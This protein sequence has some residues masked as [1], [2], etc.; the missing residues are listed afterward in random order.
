LL[1]CILFLLAP[2]DLAAV[3]STCRDL[4][5]IATGDL[6]WREI[7][8]ANVPG[9]KV[10]SPYP[11]PSFRHLYVAHELRWFLPKY[12]IWFCDS[13]LTGKLVVA[14]YDPRTGNIE[15]Y[16]LLGISTSST[17]YPWPLDDDVNVHQFEPT[18]KLHLDRPTV[19][20][21]ADGYGHGHEQQYTELPITRIP[22]RNGV[23]STS[24]L[25]IL[26]HVTVGT[27]LRAEIPM[28]GTG[29]GDY[30]RSSFMLAR[31]LQPE[32]TD[33]YRNA[34]G[35]VRLESVWP[36]PAIPAQIRIHNDPYMQIDRPECRA[37]VCEQAFWIRTRWGAAAD[38][39]GI[40]AVLGFHTNDDESIN[41]AYATLDPK[42]YTPTSR[43]PYRGI[44][45][46]DY[47][48]HGC[49][50]L[51]IHQPDDPD[52]DF[53]P[54]TI[55]RRHDETDGEFAQRRADETVFRGRLEAIKLT[56]DPNV[57]RGQCTFVAEDLGE[58]GLV[59]VVPGQE[60]PFGGARIV[61]SRGHVADDGFRNGGSNSPFCLCC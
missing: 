32:H 57:P 51:L 48:G 52:D 18:V 28:I 4:H 42:L 41:D 39:E 2:L 50:F 17:V 58:N 61:R 36:P 26:P 53:D 25:D 3:S 34:L 35:A 33:G 1:D 40:A 21:V 20:L 49:E 12:K 5:K 37:D 14:R 44:W 55:T 13:G 19:R 24:S 43:H 60:K 56:G 29:T 31:P 15:A 30:I 9:V 8:Q 59:T 47:S 6:F 54:T 11:C 7:V 38:M 27:R 23:V 22:V 46:G 10:K 16:R 45:V